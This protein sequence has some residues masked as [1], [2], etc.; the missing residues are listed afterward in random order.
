MRR[1]EFIKVGA[2]VVLSS[3]LSMENYSTILQKKSMIEQRKIPSTGELLPC[4][5]LGTWQTFD[6]G[7]DIS[8]R[9]TLKEVLKIL[10]QFGGK[11]I[12]SSPMY[13]TSEQVV[14]DL[15]Y[16]TKLQESFFYATKVWTQGKEDGIKQMKNSMKNMKREKMDLMQI[17]NLIDWNTHIKTLKS[18]KEDGKIRYWGITHY[19]ESAYDSMIN[20]IKKE[21]PDFVQFNYNIISRTSEIQLLDTSKDNNVAVIINRP[22][23]EGALFRVTKNK[24]LPEWANDYQINSWSQYFL[25]FILSHP[26]VTCVIPGTSKVE[27]IKDNLSAGFGQFPDTIM[28]TKMVKYF[29]SLL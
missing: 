24:K 22:F 9:E 2:S 25:K 13:G 11:M 21:K 7:N 27:H 10:Y 15:T 3:L 23:E 8:E 28:R 12:D 16:E 5:G 26:A 14:G 4:V 6:V 20:I 29:E 18:W 17:H 19:V 1:R